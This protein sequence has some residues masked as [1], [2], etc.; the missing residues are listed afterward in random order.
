VDQGPIVVGRK[1][2]NRLQDEV[3]HYERH[4]ETD[5]PV[6]QERTR[7]LPFIR[8][9]REVADSRKNAPMNQAWSTSK[10]MARPSPTAGLVGFSMYYQSGR[11]L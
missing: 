3:E 7:P 11:P 6:A 4:A 5:Q 1:Q 10:K 8:T 9:R 2:E